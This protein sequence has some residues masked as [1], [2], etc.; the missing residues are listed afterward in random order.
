M[1]L[2]I[3]KCIEPS[4]DLGVKFDTETVL[5]RL[6]SSVIAFDL[7]SGRL[8][9]YG[10][11]RVQTHCR[12]DQIS[13]CQRLNHPGEIPPPPDLIG[14]CLLPDVCGITHAGSRVLPGS[15]DIIYAGDSGVQTDSCGQYVNTSRKVR[16]AVYRV[17]PTKV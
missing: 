1:A 13:G 3:K 5:R 8:A 6:V 17:S 14:F 15:N 7:K 4:Y 12:C 9:I 16:N 11:S 2:K 10:V